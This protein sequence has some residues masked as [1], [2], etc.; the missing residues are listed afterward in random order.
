MPSDEPKLM[1]NQI[2]AQIIQ[3]MGVEAQLGWNEY[4]AIRTVFRNLGGSW[5]RIA[6]G[7]PDQY[8]LLQMVAT[9]WINTDKAKSCKMTI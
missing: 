6:A 3:H 5:E 7:D 8:K 4:M 9:S 1:A 2:I